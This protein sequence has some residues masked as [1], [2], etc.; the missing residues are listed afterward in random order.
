MREVFWREHMSTNDDG[1]FCNGTDTCAG[2]SCIVDSGD[3]CP[4]GSC[5]EITDACLYGDVTG[6]GV[7][8]LNDIL[9]VLDDFGNPNAC[10]GDGDIFPCGGGDGTID[11]NDILAILDAFGG[12]FAC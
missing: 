4:G 8:D 1:L 10:T 3:P 2:G 11:L 6:D 5:N 7:V 9:C 12:N